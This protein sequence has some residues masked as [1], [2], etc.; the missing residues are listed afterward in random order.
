MFDPTIDIIYNPN[1][2]SGFPIVSN[3]LKKV[4]SQSDFHHICWRAFGFTYLG[5][6]SGPWYGPPIWRM[7]RTLDVLSSR[8]CW[9]LP[10]SRIHIYIL[11]PSHWLLWPSFS[12]KQWNRRRYILMNPT[13]VSPDDVH[14][15]AP[16]KLNI[17]V[18]LGTSRLQGFHFI[19]KVSHYQSSY[20]T[21]EWPTVG[22]IDTSLLSKDEGWL[23][24]VILNPTT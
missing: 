6:Q 14:K 17:S 10:F 19:F 16:F 24:C 12:P 21:Y 22:L 23:S 9:L 11:I 15:L 3:F 8:T 4:I 7:S 13:F 18:Y 5:C 1:P 2:L 20:Q